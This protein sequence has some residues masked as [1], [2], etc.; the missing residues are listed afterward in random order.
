MGCW[1]SRW[2]I[3][4]NKCFRYYTTEV[5]S[6]SRCKKY[7]WIFAIR[8]ELR[9]SGLRFAVLSSKT[10]K[11]SSLALECVDNI[12]GRHRHA[13][14]VF[15]VRYEINRVWK[16][17]L[18]EQ[19]YCSSQF[20]PNGVW[21]MDCWKEWYLISVFSWVVGKTEGMMNVRSNMIK[22]TQL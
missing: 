8:V 19:K 22:A 3:A 1:P 7:S 9:K 21:F 5:R 20:T 12:H 17:S 15:R 10:V 16:K 18:I 6:K 13:A 4:E 2:H 14:G 11:G